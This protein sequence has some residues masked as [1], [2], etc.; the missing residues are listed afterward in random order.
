MRPTPSPTPA[1][2]FRLHGD[3][4]DA[5]AAPLL[6]AGLIGYRALRMAGDA[7]R[8]GIFG[9]GGA[10]HIVAQVAHFEGREV[11]A[12][13]RPGD[14]SAQAFARELGAIWAGDSTATPPEPLDA[15]LIFAPVGSL[16]PAALRMVAPAAESCA[17]GST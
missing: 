9:F 3:D 12:F 16:V 7:R 5:E 8:L 14:A 13:T 17:R 10:A 6:C 2:V 1:T 4:D 11:Y 15:A